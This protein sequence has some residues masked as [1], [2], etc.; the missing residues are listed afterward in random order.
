MRRV[1]ENRRHNVGFNLFVDNELRLFCRLGR[2]FWRPRG[3]DAGK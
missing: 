1:R 3:A 2:L